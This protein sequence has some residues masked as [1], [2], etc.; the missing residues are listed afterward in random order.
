M[1]L[2]PYQEQAVQWLTEHPRRF[3]AYQQGLGKT[4]IAIRAADQLDAKRIIV[5]CPA[6]ATYNWA[7]EIKRWQK[8]NRTV[9]VI[10]SPKAKITS[11]VVIISFN[12][13]IKYK[14]QLQNF[15]AEVL[16]IDEAHFIKTRD[17]A[18]TKAVYGHL[19]R[20][21]NCI[22]STVD[23]VW[24]LTGTP[25]P[26]NASE[27]W[28]HLRALWPNL[29]AET[30]LVEFTRQFCHTIDT[31]FGGRIVGNKNVDKLKEIL[32]RCMTRKTVE[33]V[34]KDLPPLRH[35]TTSLAC[36]ADYAK[37]IEQ[38]FADHPDLESL[39]EIAG[40]KMQPNEHI[41]T[42]RRLTGV[43]KVATAAEF[44]ND[45]AEQEPIVV[46]GIHKEVLGYIREHLKQKA[47]FIDGSTSQ[48]QRARQV[49]M[50]QTGE[51]Q[52]FVGQIT[53]C[54]TAITL[55]R[56]ARVVFV[57][58]SWT[59]AENAQAV[60]RCHRIGT[61]KPVLATYLALAG[62]IDEHV[63]ATLA[64]KTQMIDEILEIDND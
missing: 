35:A 4:P 1:N 47:S 54:S 40:D 43:A 12:R 18:R 37:Q 27:L 41:A 29:I 7:S 52:V 16:V 11:D 63:A 46:F 30:N 32:R 36:S 58:A 8:M 50:F 26:N 38:L 56:S 55:T 57:E 24:L 23:R 61:T 45:L 44:I 53:A 15:A 17:S 5:I 3:L 19:C 13:A 9:Q 48:E 59:P 51:T 62:T 6:I 20:M 64:R 42:L 28:T 34:M 39:V 10:D 33:Q 21:K 2:F 49:E 60:K 25:M 14:A 31:Q 22:A